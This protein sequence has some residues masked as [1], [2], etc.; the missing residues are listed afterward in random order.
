VLRG[1]REIW[2]RDGAWEVLKEVGSC[3]A[4]DLGASSTSSIKLPHLS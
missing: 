1:C 4:L 3:P 2:R